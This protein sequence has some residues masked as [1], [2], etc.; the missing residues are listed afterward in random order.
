MNINLYKFVNFY[1]LPN[2]AI[3]NN[4][5][6]DILYNT[7]PPIESHL[8][9]VNIHP[10][11]S[12]IL[13]IPFTPNTISTALHTH[14]KPGTTSSILPLPSI[15]TFIPQCLTQ[16]TTLAT[17]FH[18]AFYNATSNQTSN[19][20]E[21]TICRSFSVT[22]VPSS[23]NSPPFHPLY[24]FIPRSV[25]DIHFERIAR[26]RFQA[27]KPLASRG[28]A[29]GETQNVKCVHLFRRSH[30]WPPCLFFSFPLQ[31]RSILSVVASVHHIFQM[32]SAIKVLSIN[33]Y[34]V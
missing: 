27:R 34:S 11:V 24:S 20:S 3:N 6:T 5:N 25:H 1:Y 19:G 14:W 17:L 15:G 29:P 13:I 16:S 22:R 28:R 4:R 32:H 21:E 7:P 12:C 33:I 30:P 8:R 26:G 31:H 9:G 10:P 18:P 23:P 2:D